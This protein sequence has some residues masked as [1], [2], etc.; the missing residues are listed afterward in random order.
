M[1]AGRRFA[2]GFGIAAILA[3][4][5][6]IRGASAEQVPSDPDA[7][8]IYVAHAF[9]KALPGAKV[10]ISAPL[11]LAID[12]PQA[13]K[14]QAYLQTVYAQC[15]KAPDRCDF[16][17]ANWVDQIASTDAH[18]IGPLDRH[19][20]RMVVRPAGYVDEMRNAQKRE[21]VVAPFMAGLWMICVEDLPK[22]IEFPNAKEF[23]D[24]G[25]T[26][27][28]ALSL[29]KE[30]TRKALRPIEET[31]RPN[32]FGKVGLVA[33]DPY[34]S[35]RL[36]FPDSWQTIV[37]KG[38]TPLLVSAPGSDAVLYLHSKS[39]AEIARLRAATLKVATDARRMISTKIFRWAPTGFE[40]FND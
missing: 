2:F 28:E 3:C 33:D 24:A 18:G 17:V 23:E 8:T 39:A 7:F 40:E 26:R 11:Y 1:F 10:N 4:A 25:L 29:C 19:T 21:P 9:E 27:D 35:S 36:L 30:N 6:I 16:F 37:G 32:F 31:G 14:H 5:G 13:G 15:Q 20:L 22:S 12:V 34:E 38:R